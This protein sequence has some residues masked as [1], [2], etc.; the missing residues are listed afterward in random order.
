MR[1]VRRTVC[2]VLVFHIKFAETEIAEGDV[3]GVV[4]KDVLRLQ[5]PIDDFEAVQTLQGAQ[6]FGSIEPGAVDVEPLFTLEVVEQLAS[7]DK[8]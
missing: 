6:E 3:T 5:V 4:E 2:S 1:W 7:I 8:R